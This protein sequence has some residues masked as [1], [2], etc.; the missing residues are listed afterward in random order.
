MKPVM[1]RLQLSTYQVFLKLR[2][3]FRENQLMVRLETVQFGKSRDE[4]PCSGNKYH[5]EWVVVAI[6]T[7][8]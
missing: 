5:S 8:I 1:T 2:Q 4:E 3:H 7:L 6:W